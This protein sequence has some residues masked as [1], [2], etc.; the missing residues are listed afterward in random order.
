MK[1]KIAEKIR[2]NAYLAGDYPTDA[3]VMSL[4]NE[5]IESLKK[6]MPYKI[7]IERDYEDKEGLSITAI[8]DKEGNDIMDSNLEINIQS[9]GVDEQYWL[10]S[11]AFDF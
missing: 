6:R 9:L 3:K 7:S 2:K 5:Q 4:V 8:I 11:G 10:D 1:Y